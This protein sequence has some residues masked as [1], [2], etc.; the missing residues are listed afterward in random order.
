MLLAGVSLAAAA[1][2]LGASI[3]GVAPSQCTGDCDV[4]GSVSAAELI[5]GVRTALGDDAPLGAGA[6]PCTAFDS[7]SSGSVTV[8]ELVEGVANALCDCDAACPTAT[9][10]RTRNAAATPTP[11]PTPLAGTPAVEAAVGVTNGTLRILEFGRLGANGGGSRIGAAGSGSGLFEFPCPNGGDLR[12]SCVPGAT[13]ST[14]TLTFL[15]CALVDESQDS[16]LDASIALTVAS[17][18]FCDDGVVPP[19]TSTILEL[20]GAFDTIDFIAGQAFVAEFEDFTIT[21][22]DLSDGVSE[23]TMDGFLTADACVGR[24]R[25]ET[26]EPLRQR[27]NECPTAGLLRLTLGTAGS[28][29][30]YTPT[31]GV[32]IDFDA[33][34]D[35]DESFETCRDADLTQCGG[36]NGPPPTRTPRPGGDTCAACQDDGDCRPGLACVPCFD[37]CTGD[38]KRC[39]TFD[40]LVECEDGR[41]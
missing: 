18:T 12:I 28:L 35:F 37:R 17:S 22:R 30:R 4:D 20:N 8:D 24:I 32:A 15:A 16:I 27:E 3:R 38:V 36:G 5:R 10:T 1:P 6:A 11:T 34:G 26:L 21:T 7:N 23:V 9:P 33:D 2:A 13:S 14:S 29:I 19:E 39:S 31:G 41:F 40:G 25:V